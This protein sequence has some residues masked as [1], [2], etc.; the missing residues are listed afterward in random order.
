MPKR[1]IVIGDVHG[2][3]EALSYLL[4]FIS[5]VEEDEVYFLGDLIDRGP[6]SAQVVRLVME[7]N[8]QCLRG[9]HEQMLLDAIG[10]GRI[11]PDLFQNWM[12]AGGYTTMMSYNDKIPPE[13]LEWMGNLPIYLDLGDIFL[14]HAGLDPNLRLEQQTEKQ[15]CWIREEFHNISEPYFPDKLIVTG[16]TITFTFPKV[17]SGQIVGGMGWIAIETGVYHPRSGWLT[18]LDTEQNMV[19]QVHAQTKQKRTCPL[20]QIL[21]VYPNNNRA[22]SLK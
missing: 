18:A 1:K 22:P 10:S 16:H 14:V 7:N 17:R 5:P 20:M 11:I 4:D 8:Y 15:C 2:H 12:Y 6:H 21:V 9:N 3:Y 13:H 19:Y